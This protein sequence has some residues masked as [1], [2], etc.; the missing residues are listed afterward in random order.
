MKKVLIITY[1]W[2][3]SGG[4]GVQRW[5]KFSKFLPEYGWQPIIYTPENPEIPVR[6]NSLAKDIS[7]NV[8][9]LKQPIWE[10]YTWY[11]RLLGKKDEKIGAGLMSEGGKEGLGKKLAI[12]IRGNF[13]IPDPRKF[14]VKP[15]VKFLEDY[16]RKNEIK[17]VVT[18]GP[19]HSMHLIGLGLK[20]KLA[21]DWIA[22]FRDPW[23]NI[24][25]YRDLNLGKRADS[26]HRKLEKE[27]L[28][29]AD[30]VLS[31]GSNL[32]QELRGLGARK[33]ETITNGFD[34]DDFPES[35]L[36]PNDRFVI[37]HIGSFSRTRNH[38][39]LWD[40]LKNAIS[41]LP[42]LGGKLEILT[43]GQVDSSVATSLNEKGLDQYWNR[44]EHVPHSKVLEYQR[45]SSVLM[46]MV[47]DAPNA[48]GI[49][50]G[51]LFE[52]MASGRPIL[53]IGPMD[54]D[55]AKV[56]SYSGCGIC[57]SHTDS[58]GLKDAVVTLF[59]GIGEFKPD[60]TKIEAYSRRSLTERLARILDEREV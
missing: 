27:V 37:A 47:N 48:K 1:Y 59:N 55:A 34:R 53:C 58:E 16:I 49:L 25:F 54:G 30:L 5:L 26:K 19:P 11:R 17:H 13:F 33:V 56:I 14:W 43:V 50:P 39:A 44:V 28:A 42:E 23:T 60:A 2:P 10:P 3:P 8:V 36:L 12:W 6:D 15:S 29:K 7:P 46:L 31:V 35:D 40:G 24:D 21:I 52:Y 32:T 22:D 38:E 20:K 57:V 41:E 51:K 9:V 18:T 4:A 45:S